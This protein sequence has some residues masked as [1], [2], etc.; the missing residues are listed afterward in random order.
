MIIA[1]CPQFLSEDKS[2][3]I[4]FEC[5][6]NSNLNSNQ[7][8]YKI[9]RVDLG[10]SRS[11]EY[12]KPDEFAKFI[13]YNYNRKMSILKLSWDKTNKNYY[14]NYDSVVTKK[15]SCIQYL[16]IKYGIEKS[17]WIQKGINT[18]WLGFEYT[19]DI[20][21]N[22]KANKNILKKCN[23]H[24]NGRE[25]ENKIESSILCLMYPLYYNKPN[26]KSVNQFTEFYNS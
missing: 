11:F 7:T 23:N 21:K 10:M 6:D 18:N 2:K 13:S 12:N 14:F 8:K 20:I 15:L 25:N 1:H 4:N 24:T 26:L 22:I 16:L 9:A 3:M 19:N 5:V 17:E